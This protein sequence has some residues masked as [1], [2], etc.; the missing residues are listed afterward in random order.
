M[1]KHIDKITK[2]IIRSYFSI[3]DSNIEFGHQRYLCSILEMLMVGHGVEYWN[4]LS[5]LTKE[6]YKFAS[7]WE[8]KKFDDWIKAN[9]KDIETKNTKVFSSLTK[10]DQEKIEESLEMI[11]TFFEKQ[12]KLFAETVEHTEGKEMLPAILVECYKDENGKYIIEGMCHLVDGK[13]FT[14]KK[15]LPRHVWDIKQK[16]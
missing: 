13:Y 8:E 5:R 10:K 6:A 12:F 3:Y 2:K 16:D 1:G 9:I 4:T 15:P 11:Y 14:V 7:K